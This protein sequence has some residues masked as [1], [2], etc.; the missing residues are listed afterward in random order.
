MFDVVKQSF[1]NIIWNMFI[2]VAGTISSVIQI[3]LTLLL[4]I[5]NYSKR[6]C[7][8]AQMVVLYLYEST[9]MGS[10]RNHSISI[11]ATFDIKI[12][13]Q[14]FCIFNFTT[15][16]HPTVCC[17]RRHMKGRVAWRLNRHIHQTSDQEGSWK[18]FWSTN[19]H[20]WRYLKHGF[21]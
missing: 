7:K 16:C 20:N 10:V 11:S 21:P 4:Q 14:A 12:S 2:K 17:K 6:K 5:L 18:N 13:V 8:I 15:H 9:T 19:S 3:S 1:F